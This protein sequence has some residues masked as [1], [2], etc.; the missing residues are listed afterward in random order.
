MLRTLRVGGL[1]WALVV[2]LLA[3]LV[4][5]GGGTGCKARSTVSS[6]NVFNGKEEAGFPSTVMYSILRIDGGGALCTG[7]FLS[8]SVMLTAGHCVSD[9]GRIQQVRYNGQTVGGQDIIVHPEWLKWDA[10]PLPADQERA[11]PYDL[12]LVRFPAGTFQ[13]AGE[14]VKF[15]GRPNRVGDQFTI[16]GYGANRAEVLSRICVLGSRGS[17]GT[18]SVALMRE[19][20]NGFD[21]TAAWTWQSRGFCQLREGQAD[22]ERRNP[23]RNFFQFLRETCGAD[24][25]GRPN[26]QDRPFKQVGAGTVKRSGRNYVKRVE[27]G[28]L[29]F[30]GAINGVGDGQDAASGGGDSGGP[31]FV[32]EGGQFFLAGVTHGGYIEKMGGTWRKISAYV[33]LTSQTSIDWLKSTVISQRLDAPQFANSPPGGG[34]ANPPPVPPAGSGTPPASVPPGDKCLCGTWTTGYGTTCALVLPKA[35]WGKAPEEKIILQASGNSTC[36]SEPQCRENYGIY[37]Q[38]QRW[39]PQGF[40]FGNQPS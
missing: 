15:I 9:A 7:T 33:D 21:T 38:D 37:L 29:I 25:Q 34:T 13:L 35:R 36:Q 22:Y 8:S 39:C 1:S 16:V 32:E 31:L 28:Q 5:G 17:Q 24:D 10:S 20:A 18:C 30:D 4:G 19:S 26:L 3:T 12:A 23:G 27:S 6:P 40:A 14:P 11:V 2:V